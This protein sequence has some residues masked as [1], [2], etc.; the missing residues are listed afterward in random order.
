M[1]F[2]D[3]ADA[4]G[5]PPEGCYGFVTTPNPLDYHEGKAIWINESGFYKGLL[6]SH[7]TSCRKMTLPLRRPAKFPNGKPKAAPLRDYPGVEP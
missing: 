1:P 3:L 4:K 5:L 6:S 7:K 2:K